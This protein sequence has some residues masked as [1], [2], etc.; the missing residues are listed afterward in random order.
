MDIAVEYVSL[1]TEIEGMVKHLESGKRVFVDGRWCI[2]TDGGNYPLDM[3]K[4]E[5]NSKMVKSSTMLNDVILKGRAGLFAS[6]I[7]S[8]KSIGDEIWDGSFNRNTKPTREEAE[9]LMGKIDSL[10]NSFNGISSDIWNALISGAFSVDSLLE[11]GK[12]EIVKDY[13][14]AMKYDEK[15]CEED[16][17]VDDDYE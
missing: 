14:E 4:S 13:E 9:A 10:V 7:E 11:T 17:S 3:Y 16:Y 5:I 15:L 8:V 2:V 1:K 12:S 6:W